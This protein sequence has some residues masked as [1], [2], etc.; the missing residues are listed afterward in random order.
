MHTHIQSLLELQSQSRT[1]S[2]DVHQ[3]KTKNSPN[4][5]R[6][7]T[8]RWKDICGVL[9]LQPDADITGVAVRFISGFCK[10][11]AC[12]CVRWCDYADKEL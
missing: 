12:M 6:L 10:H 5:Q 11:L 3:N 8:W 7:S 9:A 2:A 4:P 1:V